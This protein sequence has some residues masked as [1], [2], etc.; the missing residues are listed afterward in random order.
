MWSFLSYVR[1]ISS[2]QSIQISWPEN[3]AGRKCVKVVLSLYLVTAITKIAVC[4]YCHT[5]KIQRLAHLFIPLGVSAYPALSKGQSCFY[6]D[7]NNN[8]D[9]KIET[10]SVQKYHHPTAFK[11]FPSNQQCSFSNI[12]WVTVLMWCDEPLSSS[13]ISK[14]LFRRIALYLVR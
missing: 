7:P 14:S 13:Q 6:C 11:G 2:L 3:V 1:H 8:Y 4:C 9:E 5:R 10:L 12:L